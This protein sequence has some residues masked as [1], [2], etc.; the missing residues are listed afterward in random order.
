MGKLKAE[1]MLKMTMMKKLLRG[2]RWLLK[3]IGILLL[4]LLAIILL[5]IVINRFDEP[6]KP[7]TQLW[8]DFKKPDVP[9]SGNGYLA[10]LA[11]DAQA[12][13]PIA[14]ASELVQTQHT[15]MAEERKKPDSNR[16]Q[17][18]HDTRDRLLMPRGESIEFVSGCRDDCYY[19]I[20]KHEDLFRRLSTEHAALLKRYDAMLDATAFVEDVPDD[21]DVSY[22]DN[23]QMFGLARL[24]LGNAALALESGDAKTAYQAWA[25]HQKFWQ[26]VA[27]GSVRPLSVHT[28]IKQLERSQ[29]RLT[30]MLDSHPE[31]TAIA[32][33]YALPVLDKRPQLSNALTFSLVYQFQTEARLLGDM[34]SVFATHGAENSVA[35]MDRLPLLFYQHHK[36]LNMLALVHQVDMVKSEAWDHWNLI[37]HEVDVRT[38]APCDGLH[39][40]SNQM[41]RLL[42][43]PSVH[44]DYGEDY[45]HANK[46]DEAAR[47]LSQRLE[48]MHAY[49]KKS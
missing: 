15:I 1:E 27:A 47:T 39:L 33:I 6:I 24:Y 40:L 26:L 41:G 20:F 8:L 9:A 43:C 18:Y 4:V 36:T 28:A 11:L 17:R 31:T 34:F 23:D 19:Y 7:S 14:A 3:A 38:P 30:Q 46:V 16:Y 10:F 22:P 13:D 37:P 29:S 42:A 44:Y 5:A 12:E 32:K 45:V 25:R 21:F 35:L 48:A 49:A 2:L